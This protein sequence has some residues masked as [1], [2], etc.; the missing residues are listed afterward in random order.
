MKGSIQTDL[1]C[2]VCGLRLKSLEPRG[3]YCPAHPGTIH[4]GRCR[5]MFD[6]LTTRCHTYREAYKILTRKRS[7]VDA[8]TYDARDYQ[9]KSKPLAFDRL[10]E[11]WLELKVTHLRPKSL[12]PL[13]M[14]VTRA[15]EAWGEANIKS[16]RYAQVEDFISGLKLAPKSKH[17]IL[18]A[19]RQLWAWAVARY[20]VAPL[21]SWPVLPRPEMAFR[22]TVSILDQEMILAEVKR[23]TAG[24]RPRSWLAIKWLATYIAV[25]PAEML[26]LTESQIDRRRGLLV[27]PHPKERKPKV[28]PLLDADLELLNDFPEEHPSLPFFRHEAGARR[29]LAGLPLGKQRLYRDWKTACRNL[30]I[31]G[32]DLYGGTK[33]STAMGLRNVATFE[34]VRK[35]TGHTT[36]R[37]FDRYLQL[38]GEAMKSLY[39]RRESLVS[40]DNALT[41]EIR[42]SKNEQS[43]RLQ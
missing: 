33:H 17:E 42:A 32:V 41:M 15:I 12:S 21:K 5:V 25:R 20:E 38:E 13:R 11:E 34:E 37:A 30:G 22:K 6:N 28:V 24:T 1:K 9:I 36:N 14:A 19:L 29:E 4:E 2:H 10:A 40:S 7:E 16:I 23:L 18:A 43:K 26:S 3:L 31:E 27:I 8:G 39:G 35:M